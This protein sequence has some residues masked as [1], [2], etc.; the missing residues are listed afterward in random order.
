[1]PPKATPK[2][3]RPLS[4]YMHFVK[5]MRPTVV[6]NHPTATFGEVGRKLGEMWRSLSAPDK[7]RYETMA[8]N[9]ARK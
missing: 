7:A 9:A 1:M 4:A 3:K 6:R 2:T 5:A 8:A